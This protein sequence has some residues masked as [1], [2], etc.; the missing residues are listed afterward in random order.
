MHLLADTGHRAWRIPLVAWILAAVWGVAGC[1]VNPG[2]GRTEVAPAEMTLRQSRDM[3]RFRD[4][5]TA[6]FQGGGCGVTEQGAIFCWSDLDDP[7]SRMWRCDEN[8]PWSFE[9]V[10][11]GYAHVCGLSDSGRIAC[12]GEGDGSDEKEGYGPEASRGESFVEISAA[13]GHTCAI[14]EGGGLQ[15][16]GSGADGWSTP[17]GEFRQVSADASGN[18]AIRSDGRLECWGCPP[19]ASPRQFS[20]CEE[21][22]EGQFRHV[23][24]GYTHACAV[25]QSGGV[26]CW[27]ANPPRVEPPDGTFDRVVVSYRRNCG[28]RESGRIRCWGRKPSD[29]RDRKILAFEALLPVPDP[30]SGEFIQISGGSAHFCALRKSGELEC[31]G[32]E[33]PTGEYQHPPPPVFT[34]S[35]CGEL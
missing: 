35:P 2:F 3:F 10:S 7:E 17:S 24:V 1:A 25:R 12:W 13:S 31:W 15:C 33:E 5:S 30:P 26:K 32:P 8:C 11:I 22:P 16:W 21:M 27:G 18:C 14:E 6:G 28:L 20:G 29:K 34:Y 4:I 19:D 9:S 23:D